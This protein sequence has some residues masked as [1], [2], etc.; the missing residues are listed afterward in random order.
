[1]SVS[2]LGRLAFAVVQDFPV[3]EQLSKLTRLEQVSRERYVHF[4]KFIP[5]RRN[6]VGETDRAVIEAGIAEALAEDAR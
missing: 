5:T 3:L 4:R 1:M 2:G 6:P